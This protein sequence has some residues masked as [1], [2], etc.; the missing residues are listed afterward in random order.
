MNWDRIAD[1]AAPVQTGNYP[2]LGFDPAPGIV[3]TVEEVAA[4]LG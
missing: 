3:A 1:A 2:T 4:T